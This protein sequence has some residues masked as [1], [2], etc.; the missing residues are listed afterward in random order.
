MNQFLNNHYEWK[1]NINLEE[2]DTLLSNLNGHPLQSTIWGEARKLSC[3]I[4]YHC[5][6]AFKNNVPVF[7][8]RFE[9]RIFLNYFKIAW[10]P[11]GPTYL[12]ENNSAVKFDFFKRLKKKGFFL[13]ATNPWKKIEL[14][15]A[16]HSDFYTIWID[17]TQGKEKIW[18]NLNK[19]CRYDIKKAKKMDVKII[20]TTSQ[21]DF[22]AFYSICESVSKYKKFELGNSAPLMSFL[23]SNNNPTIESCLFIAKHEN[24]LCGGA[25]LMRCGESVHYLWGAVDRNFSHLCIGESL[26]W[27]IIKWALEKNCTKYDMEGISEKQDSGV[28]RFKKKFGGSVVACPNIQ[29]FPLCWGRNIVLFLLKTYLKIKPKIIKYK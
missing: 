24:N 3:G 9:E 29:F 8:V 28:D 2:W 20:K 1:E 7:L 15:N 6:A 14:S 18:G 11:K 22:K 19:Q 16:I 25:F 21:D 17:L 27:E 5:W 4:K 13:C 23:L 12:E 26:Q 10:V